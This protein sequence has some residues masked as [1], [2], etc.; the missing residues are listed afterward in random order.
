MPPQITPFEFGESIINSG[1]M[2][3]ITCAVF[4]GDF[5]IN[6]TW[7][8]NGISVGR[9]DGITLIR[10]NKRISQLT[11]DDVNE[12][13][14]GTYVCNATNFAGTITYS[15]RLQVNGTLLFQ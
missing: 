10:T 7:S 2:A 5:P 8:L 12:I 13:H 9:I 4:K 14:A 1:D 3:T 11:I 6:I 15:T